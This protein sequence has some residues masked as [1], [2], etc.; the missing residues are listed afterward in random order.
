MPIV[1]LQP[2]DET[3]AVPRTDADDLD[4]AE[5]WTEFT[6]VP[7]RRYWT[8]AR[9]Q[10]DFLAYLREITSPPDAID[11]IGFCG[12]CYSPG[13]K[14][15]LSTA[16]G[17]VSLCEPCWD[18]WTTCDSC[19]ERYPESSII[20]LL[21]GTEVCHS[22]CDDRCSFCEHCDGYYYDAD[23]EDHSHEEHYTGCCTSPQ[24]KFTVRND[25][26]EPLA[27]DTRTVV[28]LPSGAI[29]AEGLEE[30]ST[31]LLYQRPYYDN[32]MYSSLR[33]LAHDLDTLGNQW[34]TETGNYTKRL[35]RH[36]YKTWGIKLTAEAMSQVGCIARDHSQQ[37]DVR[38][39]ITR[40]LNLSSRDFGND[41]SCWWGSYGESRCALKTNG[42]FALRTFSVHGEVT[43][44]TWVMPLRQRNGHL[45]ATFDALTPDA[46]VLF[47]G[48]GNLNGY[49]AP[50]IMSHLAGWTYRKTSFSC[51]PMY[52]NSDSGY[53]VAPEPIIKNYNGGLDLSVRQHSDLFDNEQ[54]AMAAKAEKETV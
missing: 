20:T 19:D 6:H 31:Y 26:N 17:D 29:S 10:D 13:W 53:L 24:L 33:S 30:I 51:N 23:D 1:D 50:R 5:L 25:G 27:N 34:Q 52:V 47:N 48:Y 3:D 39:E 46:F 43:G 8:R 14:D 2:P 41:G 42:G 35:S 11:D 49:T 36:A 28:A 40:N 7:A 32:S 4:L 54:A 18:S 38:I 9:K 16:R 22:C 21:G 12:N 15:D 44:R 37:V 45:Y